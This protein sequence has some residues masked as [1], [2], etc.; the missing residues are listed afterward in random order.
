[1]TATITIL[2]PHYNDPDGLALT[3]RSIEAQTWRGD[4]EVIVC[5]DGSR[6]DAQ[7]RLEELLAGTTERIRL[8]RNGVNR[9][10]PWTRNVLLEAA[11]GKYTTWCDA[12]DE[13]YPQKLELQLEGL[14]RAREHDPDAVV[15]CTCNSEWL[16]HGAVKKRLIVQRVDGDQVD[17][18]LLDRIR[19][20]LYTLLA[21]TEAF[22]NVGWFDL[23]LPRLQDIDFF[24]RF[25]AK[26]GRLVM[27]P[28]D[29]P[30]CIYHKTDVGRSGQ[31]VLRCN[32]YLFRKHAPLLLTHSRRWR[33]NRRFGQ[34]QLA[35]RFTRNNEDRL[36]TAYYLAAS[37][38][39][40]PIGFARWFVRSRGGA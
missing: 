23:Q 5:D 3:L 13:Y 31:E 40:H 28:T 18:L 24:L 7:A 15:W 33:R 9:G 39:E 37:A 4:R 6:P 25:V 19:G 8:L 38:I 11:D 36:R 32:Q 27:P 14:Y 16:W 2:V 35:A 10:R 29:E 20:Y 34:W 26:G 21:P 12:G 17:G 22:K 1:M 30:L